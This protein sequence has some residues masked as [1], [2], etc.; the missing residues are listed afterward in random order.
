M[1]AEALTQMLRAIS[2]AIVDDTD[3]KRG[4]DDEQLSGMATA[5]TLLRLPRW[6]RK[7]SDKA[8]A[9]TTACKQTSVDARCPKTVLNLVLSMIKQQR[10]IVAEAVSGLSSSALSIRYSCIC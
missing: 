7:R 8:K 2:M 5:W 10:Q 4:G 9:A 6:K 3:I 1:H